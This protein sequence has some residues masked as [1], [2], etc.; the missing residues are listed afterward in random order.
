M[1]SLREHG[2]TDAYFHQE[3]GYTSRLDSLQAA[4]LA[5]K[6]PYLEAW[7]ARR[8]EIAKRYDKA[9]ATMKGLKPLKAR[10][11]SVYHLYNILSPH[12][13]D[14]KSALAAKGI[15]SRI[16]YP[17]A[18]PDLPPLKAY[19]LADYPQARQFCREILALPI[20]PRLS[21]AEVGMVIDAIHA[22][23]KPIPV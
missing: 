13:D 19:A 4:V 23:L 6:L 16:Y 5:A 3:I 11:E 2:K 17:H 10:G 7:N 8:R 9:F 14:L 21:D 1:R 12:R 18:L 20:H 22:A 15:E